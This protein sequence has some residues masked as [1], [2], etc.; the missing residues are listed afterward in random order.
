MRIHGWSIAAFG[1]IVEWDVSGLAHH[2]VVVVLGP[3]ESGKS[4][5]FEF[6]ASALFGFSPATADTHPYRPWDSRFLGGRL[7]GQL[8]VLLS[9]SEVARI[10]RWLTSR[11]DGHIKRGEGLERLANRQVPWVGLM[12][13][14]VFKNVYA[15]TQEE[16][17][18]LDERAWQQVQD[19]VLGG[20]SY[21]F[22]RP[23]RDVVSALDAERTRRW[24]PDRR[25]RPESRAIEAEIRRLRREDLP[26]ALVR[27]P[28]IERAD[29]RLLEIESELVDNSCEL[30]RVVLALD[31]NDKLAPLVRRVERMRDLQARAARLAPDIDKLAETPGR[32][33][34]LATSIKGLQ[35]ECKELQR[36]LDERLEEL[37]IKE[38][39]CRLLAARNVIERL[40]DERLLAQEDRSR[41]ERMDRALDRCD[42]SLNEMAERSL[43]VD[44][45]D[46]AA[47]DAIHALSV[48][49]LRERFD[50]W[51]R[52]QRAGDEAAQA[53]RDVHAE[54]VRLEKTL[55]AAE[56]P[57][58]FAS[59]DER[60]RDLRQIEVVRSAAAE[61]PSPRLSLATPLLAAIAL[62]GLLAL[63]LGVVMAGLIGAVL[64]VVGAGA[65]VLATAVF[66]SRLPSSSASDTDWEARLRGLGLSPGVDLAAEI[67]STQA[68]RDTILRREGDIKQIARLREA[69]SEAGERAC[70]LAAAVQTARAG[71]L[72]VIADVPVAPVHRETPRDGLV[73]DLLD[74]RQTIGDAKDI[75][76]DRDVV[77]ARLDAWRD[78][79]G[80]LR[81]D[82]QRDLPTD[83]FDAVPAAHRQLPD[84]LEVKRAAGRAALIVPD[85]RQRLESSQKALDEAQVEFD[86]IDGDLV[87]LDPARADPLIGLAR[88]KR[89][90]ELRDEAR[91]AHA[92]IEHE[93]P[94]WD[95]R[96]AEAR[97]LSASGETVGLSDDERVTYE[98]RADFPQDVDTPLSRGTIQQIY[99]ALRLAMVDLVEGDEPLPLFLDEMFVNWDPGP[100]DQRPCGLGQHARRPT[101]ISIH[102]R[103]VLGRARNSGRAGPH[104][105]NACGLR[106]PSAYRRPVGD[107]RRVGLQ[108]RRKV[109]VP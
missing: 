49:E 4:A 103:P 47:R 92:E 34:I 100:H 37:K 91:S 68:D 71:F 87:E 50:D 28:Q 104:R 107:C 55:E 86:R 90:L 36:E 21:D 40:N 11:P 57:P 14:D 85:L 39:T 94:D 101:G 105:A 74:M 6:F 106:F 99:F 25:G 22:L 51:R 35:V 58:A 66:W 98:L 23:S 12:T 81:R 62:A 5:L 78:A 2:D 30:Q 13:R 72:A 109:V 54:I 31:R 45:V 16:S 89:A 56:P 83:P 60:L 27:R 63:V 82:L 61:R 70:S 41:I 64:V 80:R 52:A 33:A 88:V 10:D 67:S 95:V 53:V 69:E 65:L 8:E 17:L 75:R 97:E 44:Q 1:P 15:L 24:R 9:S 43:A 84:A 59:L 7:D 96:V 18:G 73:S 102:C 29:A 48:A 32:R 3:N 19:R 108:L 42:G 46:D 79:A 26:E 38:R 77:A 93:T 20:S 76:R